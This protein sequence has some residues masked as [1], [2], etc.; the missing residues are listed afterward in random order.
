ME[1]GCNT[2]SLKACSRAEAFANMKRLGFRAVELWVGHASYLRSEE[3]PLAIAEEARAA[4]LAIRAY[5]IGGLFRL[6]PDT[7]VERLQRAFTFARELG[8]DL[9]TGIIDRQSVNAVDRLC[10]EQAMRFAIENHW[11][12]EFARPGDFLGPL[13]QCSPAVGVNIDT[14][15]F[16]L[17][18]CDLRSA[19][20]EL[21]ARTMNVHLKAV[22]RVRRIGLMIRRLRQ[23]Y[24]ID[25]DLPGPGDQ[26]APF[27]EALAR[28]GYHGM[29][30]VE[31]EAEGTRLDELA[32]YRSRAFELLAEREPSTTSAPELVRA[33]HES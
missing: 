22:K 12:T 25:P 6:P 32:C 13:R 28:A 1:I 5:C 2:Y 7:V 30:A 18:G 16:A 4:G 10:N 19:A 3:S 31:H 26:L 27:V 24:R 8:V 14:G 21:G 20:E 23:Q 29:L 17:L 11:Y 9:V 15:H 33:A